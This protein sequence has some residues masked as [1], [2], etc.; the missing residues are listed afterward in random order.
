M[1]TRIGLFGAPR[2]TPNLGVSAIAVEA[3]H[4]AATPETDFM[5]TR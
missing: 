2:D 5:N 3:M 4:A 1:A